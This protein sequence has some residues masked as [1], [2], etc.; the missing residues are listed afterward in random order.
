MRV[1]SIARNRGRTV[2]GLKQS[3]RFFRQNRS[4]ENLFFALFT[5]FS[6]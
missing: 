1:E 5:L 3:A 4:N 6:V 2:Y